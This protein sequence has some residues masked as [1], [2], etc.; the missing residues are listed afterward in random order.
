MTM[1]LLIL[2]EHIIFSRQDGHGGTITYH[3]YDSVTW[4]VAAVAV[5]WIAWLLIRR[6]RRLRALQRRPRGVNYR[7][8]KRIVK[9]KDELS[10]QYLRAGLSNNIHAVGIG[11]LAPAGDYCIQVF[12]VDA[13]QEL[14]PGAG[15]ATTLAGSFFRGIPLL[16][17]QMA[18]MGFLIDTAVDFAAGQYANGIRDQQAVIVG[19]ISGAN[20]NLTGQSGTIGYFCTRKSKLWRRKEVYLLSNSHVFVDL[21]NPK[22]D[23][24]ELIVQPS[25]GERA[26]NRPI[27]TLTNFSR[28][29]F[30]GDTNEP[31][32][33]DAAICKLWDSQ[34]HQPLIPLIGT[35]NGY[36]PQ[37]DV[38]IGEAVRKCGRTTGYTEGRIFSIDLD[39]WI[40]YDRTRQSAFF[41]NQFL[42]EPASP[43]YSS[44]VDKGDSGSIVID[45]GQRAIGLVFAG[46]S[47]D[48]QTTGAQAQLVQGCGV[49]NPI[50]EVLDR[51]KIELLI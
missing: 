37:R 25:P 45:A 6:Y 33:I 27:G 44:F 36:V 40:G 7:Q 23:D 1:L 11:R 30:D 4:V 31:N 20:V 22:A 47:A 16:L 43:A 34:S 12:V 26:S 42:I 51:L 48:Q 13:T 32:I 39:I 15:P 49:V 28:L 3:Y 46:T 19:G 21:Q 10:S 14:W 35:V 41:K 18:R 24:T 9:I 5:L 2:K 8:L 38:E 50:S 29:T 17:I